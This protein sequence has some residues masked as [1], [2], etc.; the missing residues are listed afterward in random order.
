LDLQ[1]VAV[2]NISTQTDG[3]DEGMRNNSAVR[4]L[5][6][7]NSNS[8]TKP[9]TLRRTSS[10]SERPKAPFKVG[11]APVKRVIFLCIS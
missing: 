4:R 6:R 5:S 3:K 10:S 2:S 8:E 7:T 11:T 1:G 9:P